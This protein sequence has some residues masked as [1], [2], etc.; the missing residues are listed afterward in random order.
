MNADELKLYVTDYCKA[1]T[2][3]ANI[4]KYSRYFKGGNLMDMA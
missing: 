1:N 2:N 4:A 3:E